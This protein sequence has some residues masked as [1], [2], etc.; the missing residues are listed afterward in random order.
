MNFFSRPIADSLIS[1]RR[2]QFLDRLSKQSVDADWHFKSD[3]FPEFS[4]KPGQLCD[5]GSVS[6]FLPPS[7]TGQV[8]FVYADSSYLEDR[9]GLDDSFWIKFNSKK[10]E[11]RFIVEKVFASYASALQCYLAELYI[12]DHYL[13]II[14]NQQAYQDLNSVIFDRRHNVFNFY[15]L[16][17]FDEELCRRAFG[18][19]LGEIEDL[20]AGKIE[21]VERVGAG[22]MIGSHLDLYL[23]SI[24][25]IKDNDKR[26]RSL[27][28]LDVY[29]T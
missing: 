23:E 10:F 8:Q 12:K 7:V 16:N 9:A 15:Q 26:I 27:L 19:S 4:D 28:G 3:S 29:L 20:L 6:K 17:F 18:M 25:L 13:P 22:L 2:D 14:K 1:D 5:V 21:L 11:L 24:D